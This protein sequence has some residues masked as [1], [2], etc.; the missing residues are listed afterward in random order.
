MQETA[1]TVLAKV[2][3]SVPAADT[4]TVDPPADT[5]DEVEPAVS[6]TPETTTA[7]PPETTAVP[8]AESDEAGVTFD[9]ANATVP[10]TP[11]P[12]NEIAA[13]SPDEVRAQDAQGQSLGAGSHPAKPDAPGQSSAPGQIG[14]DKAN[15]VSKPGNG[16]SQDPPKT[17]N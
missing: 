5:P 4:P 1:A 8:P 17:K 11:A 3:I 14:R 10:T 16:H 12:A 6:T 13:A 2:G 7:A 9:H 15:D